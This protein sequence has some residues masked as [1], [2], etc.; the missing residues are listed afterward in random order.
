V[1]DHEIVYAR[2]KA[3]HIAAILILVVGGA[4]GVVQWRQTAA[5]Y[6]AARLL[7]ALPLEHAVKVYI[8][9]DALRS[10]RLLE[11]LAGSPASEE[12]DY[13]RFVEDTGFNYRTDLSSAAASFLHGDVYMAVRGRFDWKRLSDYAQAQHGLCDKAMCTMPASQRGR[14]ISYHLLRS[15]VLAVAVTAEERGSSKIAPPKGSTVAFVPGAPVWISAPGEAFKDLSGLPDGSHILSPL[16]EAQEASF[17]VLEREIR[18][19]AACKSPEVAA[20]MVQQFTTTTN[21]LRAMLQRDK[22]KP[23]SS[24]LS[25]VLVAGKFEAQAMHAIGTWPLEKQFIESLFSGSAR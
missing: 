14:N 22:L 16:A 11:L 9:V 15:N 4:L 12:S 6:D 17:K 23:N 20:R 25:G 13:Q 2:L 19:D 10:A 8:D 1:S 18:L 3:W 21:L 24:D 7:Q 5:D